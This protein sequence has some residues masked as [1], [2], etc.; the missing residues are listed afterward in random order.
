MMREV[1]QRRFGRAAQGGPGARRRRPLARPRADRRRRRPAR[2]PRRHPGRARRRRR[3]AGGRRQGA[4]PR[5]RPGAVLHGRAARRS[6]STPRDPVLYFLQRLRD[7]AHR[8]AITDA[9]RAG[10]SKSLAHSALD[11]VAG[12]RR[13]AQA[14]AAQPFR[15]GPRGQAGGLGR[16]RGGARDQP[17]D[18]APNLCPF[19]PGRAAGGR[20]LIAP[21]GL[22]SGRMLTDLPN[23]L[24]LSRIAAIPL[25][26]G[27]VA[28]R[29]PE[30]DLAACV[31]FSAAAVTDYFDGRLARIR[32][33]VSAFGRMLDPIADKLLVGA[34]LMLLAG[35]GRLS[36]GIL[37]CHRHPAPGDPGQRA[38]RGTSP[39]CASAFRSRGSRSGRRASRWVP[40]SSA[41]RRQLR[42]LAAPLVSP[43]LRDRG[44]D[45]VGRR[46]ADADDG[47]GLLDRRSAA[48]GPPGADRRPAAQSVKLR[49][50][51][52]AWRCPGPATCAG[53]F[54]SARYNEGRLPPDRDRLGGPTVLRSSP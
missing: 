3:A 5:R 22:P 54:L 4:G 21:R 40:W 45:A 41:G 51:R 24:T 14:G 23:L 7:E 2:P 6:R 53:G 1:L 13:G 48:C 47:V 36:R 29:R 15:L 18:R 27:L 17:G 35:E 32:R 49:P 26:I 20:F 8:F 50:R 11:E 43:G 19:P 9:S 37:P 34:T 33:Q 44:S 12:H 38:A 10:R 16:A 46:G 52:F 31:V 30:A 42:C 25:L 28:T 39:G